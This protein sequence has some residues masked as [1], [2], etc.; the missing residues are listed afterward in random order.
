MGKPCMGHTVQSLTEYIGQAKTT[1]GIETSKY[2]VEKKAKAILLVVA[3]ERG[4]A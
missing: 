4:T 1:G 3:S 2:P